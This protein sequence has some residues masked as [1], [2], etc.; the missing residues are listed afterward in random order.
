MSN[1]EKNF[2][3]LI[4]GAGENALKALESVQANGQTAL[5]IDM[6]QNSLMTLICQKNRSSSTTWDDEELYQVFVDKQ[7]ITTTEIESTTFVLQT[8][9]ALAKSQFEE[10]EIGSPL[11]LDTLDEE[12]PIESA[13]EKNTANPFISFPTHTEDSNLHAT[14]SKIESSSTKHIEES[15]SSAFLLDP[16][17]EEQTKESSAVSTFLFHSDL[18]EEQMETKSVENS[19]KTEESLDQQEIQETVAEED[20]SLFVFPQFYS[21]EL[22]ISESKSESSSV[23]LDVTLDQANDSEQENIDDT[24][25]SEEHE[26]QEEVES[27]TVQEVVLM[28]ENDE[29]LEADIR[30]DPTQTFSLPKRG[31]V[32]GSSLLGQ[33]SLLWNQRETS[34]KKPLIK[35]SL[36]GNQIFE[37]L[38]AKD[39]EE[40]NEQNSKPLESSSV[41]ENSTIQDS[42]SIEH[43]ESSSSSIQNHIAPIETEVTKESP[44]PSLSLESSANDLEELETSETS[45]HSKI[46]KQDDTSRL[47]KLS[48][49]QTKTD[50]LKNLIKADLPSQQK[51][52][53]ID[54]K[55]NQS[56]PSQSKPSQSKP[57]QSKPSQSKPSQSKPSQSKPSQSKPSQSKPSMTESIQ[58]EA[59]HSEVT[60]IEPFSSRRRSRANKKSRLF[61]NIESFTKPTISKTPL[62]QDPESSAT[63]HPPKKIESIYPEDEFDFL[64]SST[65][66]D[67]LKR[68][69]IEFEDAYGG[70]SS[71]EEFLTP[72]SQGNRKRQEMDKL[73]KRKLA[74]RGLHNLINNL[75]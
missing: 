53:K 63:I 36:L 68:D 70:Y 57:S 30:E 60:P 62:T 52:S 37:K 11:V 9:P 10:I 22:S 41:M 55:P 20:N 75:G 8:K 73:E 13:H 72:F 74:L 7:T 35:E 19:I 18:L 42:S 27:P 31:V 26:K 3:V 67:Q 69:D 25:E 16:H 45:I 14:D 40:K 17:Q 39:P 29:V 34:N 50:E 66:S 61:A 12:L 48:I 21:G 65:T 49:P 5:W 59:K 71:W 44:I 2:D 56:K 15:S 64:E 28:E 6:D 46:K 1:E 58:P 4:L 24:A 33:K 54:V 23:Q 43:K 38:L 51:A 47:K 32:I